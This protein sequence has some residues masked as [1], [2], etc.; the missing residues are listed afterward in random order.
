MSSFTVEAVLKASGAGKFQRAF[1]NAEKSMQGFEKAGKKIG[2]LGKKLTAGLTLP[3]AAIGGVAV[4][5]GMEFESSMSKVQSVTGASAE[6]MSVLEDAARDAGETTNKSAQEAAEAL[7]YMGLAGFSVKESQEALLPVLKLSSAAGMELGATSDLVTDTMGVMGIE[8]NE[9][10]GYLDTLAETSRSSNTSVEEL[11]EA[12]LSVGG[13]AKGLGVETDELSV[14]LGIL[15]DNGIKGSE[16][17]TGL[18]AILA[19]MTAPTGRAKE[20]MDDLGISVFDADGNFIG[21]EESMQL[22][23]DSMEGMTVEQKNMYKAMIAGKGHGDTLNAMLNGLGDGYDDLSGDIDGADG[24]LDEMYDTM[25]DNTKGAIDE[26]MSSISELGLKIYDNLQPAVEKLVEWVQKITDKF[27]SFD[28]SQQETIVNIGL[29]AAALGP[30]MLIVG[31]LVS[32][33]SA[34]GKAFMILK[35]IIVAFGT[36]IG[37]V[38]APVALVV[39]A[40]TAL[41]AAGV[42]LYKNW[43]T[44]K[45]YAIEKWGEIKDFFTETIPEIVN[46][47]MEWFGALPGRMR[48]KWNEIIENVTEWA[49]NMWSKATEM[50]ST[51]LE[52]VMEFFDNLPEKI[53]FAIGTALG[54]V[55]RWAVD[56]WNKAKEMGSNFLSSVVE[57]FQQLPGRVR[58]FITSAYNSVVTWASNMWSKAKETG[59]NFVNGVIQ[60]VT[61]LPSKIWNFLS[62]TISDAVKWGSDLAAKGRKAAKDLVK[63]TVKKAKELP[64]KMKKVGKNL[65]KGLWN[66]IKNVKGWVMDKVGGFMTS[67]LDGAK[68]AFGVASPSKEFMSIGK[69]LDE[70]LVEG[71]DDGARDV[72]KTMGKMIDGVLAMGEQPIDMDMNIGGQVAKSNGQIR[73]SISHE[74]NN[75]NSKQPMV[76]SVKVGDRELRGF[77][78]DI[79]NRQNKTIDFEEAYSI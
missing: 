58:S 43:D 72:H 29:F 17:G 76:L 40:I 35:P 59:R 5:S 6:D 44:V 50:A 20:A 7:E 39:G 53:G 63:G 57:F 21:I 56:M 66:G 2:G 14:S 26:L 30:V 70:G 24:A 1:A 54:T 12:I 9:L 69:F 38:T 67:V 52:N 55:A 25:T 48:E 32:V 46:N 64:D 42:A 23:E 18:N 4:K 61:N 47:I 65:V 79:T 77:V 13:T 37:G 16:A 74:I 71:I 75:E 3:L 68:E 11:G 28:K 15:A 33:I 62:R 73:S 41:V 27:N 51:F 45:E 49:S 8:V 10:D 31:K 19:N 60:F 78:D 22:L 36:V 34:V